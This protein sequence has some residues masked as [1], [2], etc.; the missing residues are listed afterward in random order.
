ML[1]VID[2]YVYQEALDLMELHRSE[3]RRIYIVSSSPEEIVRPLARHFGVAGVIATRPRSATDGRYTGE[4]A[5]Y[6]YG[7]SKADAIRALAERVGIDL[8]AAP[9]RTRTRSPDLPM[10]EAVGIP[11]R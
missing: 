3:G 1:D 10:L 6:S 11:S 7:E 8:A 5:F 2:P 9:T 4:L